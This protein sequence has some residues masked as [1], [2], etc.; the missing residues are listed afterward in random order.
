VAGIRDGR[1]WPAG[2]GGG[3]GVARSPSLLARLRTYL[4]A[5]IVVTAPVSI[6]FFIVWQILDFLDRTASRLIP[7]RYDPATYLPF[8]IP[9]LGLLV[10]LLLLIF[11]GWFAAGFVGRSLMR[12]GERVLDRMP[13]VRS[14]YGTLKQ[15]FETVLAQSSRSFREVVL[16]EW[17]RRGLWVIGFVTGPTSGEIKSRFDGDFVNIFLPTT[18]NPTSGF[19]VFVPA[20]DLI[21]L[22]MSVEEGIKLVIS[23]GIVA[24]ARDRGLPPGDPSARPQ[25]SP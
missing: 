25:A 2:E 10:M 15:I 19:L 1:R 6:T 16:L 20:R 22:D 11:I 24:P 3:E 14:I 8:G 9:G 18:P 7:D 17:P 23:G 12:A 13:V 5:G 4:F 21:H